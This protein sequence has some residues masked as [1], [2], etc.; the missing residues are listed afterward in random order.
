M[1]KKKIAI[2]LST[3]N[4]QQYLAEQLQ[5]LQKQSYEDW[6]L[7]I[8]DDGS[9]DKTTHIIREFCESD[10]RIVWVNEKKQI[11]LGVKQS[12]M[13]LLTDVEADYYMFC[14]QDDVW[15]PNKISITLAAMEDNGVPQLTFT[16]LR[17]VD[18]KL[19][20]IKRESV[21][22]RVKVGYW[23][24]AS[25]VFFDNVVTGCTVMINSELKSAVLPVNADA[26]VMH[27]WFLTIIAA[28]IGTIH[29][30]AQ[31]TILYRQHQENQVGINVS[32]LARLAKLKNFKKFIKQTALQVNQ[33]N[34]SLKKTDYRA[35]KKM[36]RFVNFPQRRGWEKLGLLIS[37]GG[38][39]KHTLFGTVALNLALFSLKSSDMK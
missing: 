17:L 13:R 14:D 24:D 35:S 16:D 7:Y 36:N 11:N 31:E 33:A 39:K 20:L 8:R 30:V 23:T 34:L 22:S 32:Y 18:N 5:S 10:S 4:G 25:N 15:L 3:Y 1:A 28:Q 29:F 12:F 19:N 21:L 2:L 27:D 9:H 6:H 26:I 37:K 38:F